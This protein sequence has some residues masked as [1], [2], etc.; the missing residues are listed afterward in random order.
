MKAIVLQGF[1][2][3]EKLLMKE[4]PMPVLSSNEVLIEVRAISINPVDVR[5]RQGSAMADYLKDNHPL[6][7]GWDISGVVKETGQKVSKF[8]T[9]DEVFGLIN[10]LGHGKGYAEYVAAPESNLALKPDNITY[11]EAAAATLSA[12]TAWQ[13]L[14]NYAKLKKGDRVLILAA[15]GGV[16]HYAVQ[17]AKFIGAYVIGVSSSKNKEFVLELGADEHV[18]Y[19][20]ANFEDV[21]AEVDIVVDAFSKESL[22][23]SLQIVKSNGMILSLL[24]FISEE[25]LAKAKEKKVDIHYSLVKSSGADMDMIAGLL[26]KGGIKSYVSEVFSFA[27]MR[28]AHLSM[29]SERTVGKIV[30]QVSK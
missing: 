3:V 5:T 25:V 20:E 26:A 8:K 18:A 7:L 6:I 2:G 30:V 10:F 13:L 21:V 9:G 16:G 29:E 24:P 4:L 23:K 15:S 22:F 28:K 11:V 12:L 14:H 19:D 27:D 17:I 1:G